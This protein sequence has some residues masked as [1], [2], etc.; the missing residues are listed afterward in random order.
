MSAR[1]GI[2][3]ARPVV[4]ATFGGHGGNIPLATAA[5]NPAFRLVATDYEVGAA[6]PS[7][8]N[9]TVVSADASTSASTRWLPMNPAPPVIFSYTSILRVFV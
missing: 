8:P 3:E 7:H 5:D 4:L 6:T 2:A 9:L 1:L